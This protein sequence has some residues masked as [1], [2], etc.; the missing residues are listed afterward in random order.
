[1]F[2]RRMIKAS[3]AGQKAKAQWFM[4]DTYRRE[5][6]SMPKDHILSQLNISSWEL[7]PRKYA[8]IN[9]MV[10]AWLRETVKPLPQLRWYGAYSRKKG[11][12]GMIVNHKS[13]C[14]GK[15][16]IHINCSALCTEIRETFWHE[17]L[18]YYQVDK[19]EVTIVLY[20]RCLLKGRTYEQARS[21]ENGWRH[22]ERIIAAR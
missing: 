8:E 10:A 19:P 14:F 3:R 6:Q 17:F 16:S 20:E 4:R 18:H 22:R 5:I 1:M 2:N 12:D 7:M 11:T 13:T 21:I 15:P 9:V